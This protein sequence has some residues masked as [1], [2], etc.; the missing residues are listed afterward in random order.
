[1]KTSQIVGQTFHEQ[2][3]Q[4]FDEIFSDVSADNGWTNLNPLNPISG[5]V[6]QDVPQQRPEEVLPF[7]DN[8]DLDL[9]PLD[10]ITEANNLDPVRSD[11]NG[12]P[13]PRL[14][15]EDNWSSPSQ[16]KPW[17]PDLGKEIQPFDDL[18]GNVIDSTFADAR[19]GA[20]MRHLVPNLLLVAALSVIYL[21]RA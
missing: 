6:G 18:F 5:S 19:T 20:G 12:P 17:L 8:F 9:E 11:I 4:S 2:I 7:E 10:P 1:M 14:E 13:R 21:L 15:D 3:V 16:R